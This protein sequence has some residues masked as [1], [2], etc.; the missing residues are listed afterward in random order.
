MKPL[1][2][3]A[4]ILLL[5]TASR[6]KAQSLDSALAY[7]PLEKGNAWEYSVSEPPSVLRGYSYMLVSGDTLMSN[8]KTYF[9]LT[10]GSMFSLFPQ[11]AFLRVDSSTANIEYYDTLKQK[12]SC[13]DSL[14]ARTGDRTPQGFVGFTGDV[15]VL[16]VTTISRACGFIGFGYSLSYGFG[17]TGRGYVFAGGMGDETDF[18]IVYA[19]ISGKEFG[20]LLSADRSMSLV[21]GEFAL[22]QNYPNPFNPSTTI[23]YALPQRT[24]VTLSVH[25]TLGQLVATLVDG[26][27]EAGYHTVKFDGSALA[28]GVY[29]YRLRAGDYISSKRMVVLR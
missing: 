11:P 4:I 15:S 9:I 20:T 26:T 3:A 18:E 23:R 12:E 8:G 27:E 16:G 29:F 24:H 1:G 10:G 13:W 17:V 5:M 2:A 7:F 25:N 19:R 28:S 22:H 6:I 14:L 21:S